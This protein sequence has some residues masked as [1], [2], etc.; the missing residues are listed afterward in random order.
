MTIRT[1]TVDDVPA[2]L[3]GIR[4][5]A[6]YEKLSDAV[7]ADEDALA[8]TLFGPRPCAEVLLAEDDGAV[9]GFALFFANYSTFLARPGLYLEDLFVH[10]EYRGRGHGLALMRE[11][12]RIA[13][14][15]GCGR[16]EWS[17]LDWN[18]PAIDF[19]RAMGAQPMSDWTVFRLDGEALEALAGS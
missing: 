13:R 16:F 11:I 6:D 2:I 9:A 10:P 18:A 4:A 7:V 5:L 14:Q 1:A 19:Y 15:R 17:V 12:A 8:A 3:A